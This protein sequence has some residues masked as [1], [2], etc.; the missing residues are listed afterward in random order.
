LTHLRQEHD[1][2]D[3]LFIPSKNNLKCD[4]RVGSTSVLRLLGRVEV[5]DFLGISL[6]GCHP[7]AHLLAT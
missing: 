3:V 4:K 6:T 1:A 5:P 7:N 2:Y